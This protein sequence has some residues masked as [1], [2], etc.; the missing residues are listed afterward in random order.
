MRLEVMINSGRKRCWSQRSDR[1][2]CLGEVSLS[3]WWLQRHSLF[4]LLNTFI[5]DSFMFTFS[6][7]EHH[8]ELKFQAIPIKLHIHDLAEHTQP[9]PTKL[10]ACRSTKNTMS[11]V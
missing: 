1:S 6:V 8:A 10:S 3:K 5:L 4:E 9:L 7:A 2:T 11:C